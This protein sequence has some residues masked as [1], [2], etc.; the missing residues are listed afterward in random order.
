M[1]IHIETAFKV[2]CVP[3]KSGEFQQSAFDRRETNR[4]LRQRDLDYQQGRFDSFKTLVVER[5]E[6]GNAVYGY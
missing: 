5:Y 4:L 1:C 3:K 6:F 2:D